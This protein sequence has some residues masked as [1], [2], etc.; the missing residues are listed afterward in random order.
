[1]KAAVTMKKP[2]L[3]VLLMVVLAALAGWLAGT[4]GHSSRQ[5]S[6]GGPTVRGATSPGSQ[7]PPSFISN[8]RHTPDPAESAADRAYAARLAQLPLSAL[9][10]EYELGG[11]DRALQAAQAKFGGEVSVMTVAALASG[12]PDAPALKN[13]EMADPGNALPNLLRAGMYASKKDWIRMKE[14]LEAGAS[15]QELSIR[16]RERK[17]AIL[18]AVIANPD[19]PCTQVLGS[20]LD[21][22]LFQNIGAITSALH[23]SGSRLGQPEDVASLGVGIA[24]QLR[25]MGLG[26]SDYCAGILANR[27]EIDLLSRVGPEVEYGETGRTVGEQI[28]LLKNEA[29]EARRF[30]TLYARV[31]DPRTSVLT[32]R[33]FFARVRADGELS[34]LAWFEQMT[35]AT[36]KPN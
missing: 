10:A 13:L 29:S 26:G 8:T 23:E 1:M 21:A 24:L 35:A 7:A 25:Q 18:D 12:S 11:D 34:A 36:S 9:L 14:Q 16:T 27:L 20:R 3:M 33:Q 4:G 15:K 22:A 30:E 17:A 28:T 32:R 6:P 5:E 31:V 19:L 2:S